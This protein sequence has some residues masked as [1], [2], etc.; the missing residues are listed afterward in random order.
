MLASHYAPRKNLTLGSWAEFQAQQANTTEG[1]GLLLFAKPNDS[2]LAA[3]HSGGARVETLSAT[4]DWSEAAQ[5]LFAVLRQMDE[6]PS[7]KRIFAENPL[8]TELP[9]KESGLALALLD[10]LTRAAA[11]RE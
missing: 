3:L 8:H 11:P 4:S 7:V 9:G 10:R 2:E 5:R 6:N 1:W